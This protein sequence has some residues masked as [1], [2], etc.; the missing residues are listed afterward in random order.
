MTSELSEALRSAHRANIDRY[1]RLLQTH[2]TDHEREFVERRIAEE[3]E[4]LQRLAGG[5]ARFGSLTACGAS[6]RAREVCTAF[7]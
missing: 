4:A 5:N 7:S 3:Q 1:C 6:P 2:L